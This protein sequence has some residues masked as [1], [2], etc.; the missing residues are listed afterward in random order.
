MGNVIQ[1]GPLA[2]EQPWEGASKAL[3]HDSR[4]RLRLPRWRM[5]V[6]SSPWDESG[7]KKAGAEGGF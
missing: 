1:R 4:K 5:K 2:P 3:R 6:P 7:G